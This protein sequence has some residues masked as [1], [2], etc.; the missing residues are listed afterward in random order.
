M[1][2]SAIILFAHLPDFE[3]RAKSLSYLSSIKTTKKISA[4]L[5]Q[6]FYKLSKQTTADTFL[7]DTY[8]QKG[9]TF[10]ERISNA[11]VDIYTKGYENVICIGNDCPD[12]DLKSLQKAITETEN[13]NVVLGPTKDGGTYLIGLPKGKFNQFNFQNSSWQT[14]KNFK[15]LKSQ[16]HNNFVNLETLVDFD[17]EKDLNKN[18]FNNSI[19]KVLFHIIN[20]Y[21]VVAKAITCPP[22]K[23]ILLDATFLKGPPQYSI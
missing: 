7:I 5:T 16:F 8:H 9:E 13:G 19:A 17:K 21:R 3:A 6:H 18:K 4:Y 14:N 15:S 12:L 2:K 23:S 1:T 11:Y 22:L 10:G 20:F